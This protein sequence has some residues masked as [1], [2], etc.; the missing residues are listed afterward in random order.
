MWHDDGGCHRG[1][2]RRKRRED[3]EKFG[4]VKSRDEHSK[5]DY[6]LWCHLMSKSLNSWSYHSSF[7]SRK[8]R[9]EVKR[10]QKEDVVCSHFSL[11]FLPSFFS[12]LSLSLP[13]STS[14][15]LF[16]STSMFWRGSRTSEDR[17]GRKDEKEWERNW[18][19][20]S[21]EQNMG[22]VKWPPKWEND[23]NWRREEKRLFMRLQS[24]QT[25]ERIHLSN[26]YWH[27][28]LLSS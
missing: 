26:F 28:V 14:V 19:E 24:E 21:S 8:E 10:R 3:K 2:R 7:P 27:H 22:I 17:N 12:S 13:S 4:K 16:N 15:P 18:E 11:P 20:I 9:R 5:N 6:D 25:R 1:E 23:S